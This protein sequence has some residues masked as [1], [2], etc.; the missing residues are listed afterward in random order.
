M[1]APADEGE[2]EGTGEPGPNSVENDQSVWKDGYYYCLLQQADEENKR[3]GYLCYNCREKG[4]CW[5]DCPQ[6]LR[7]ALQKAKDREGI[8]EQRLN[9]SWGQWSQGSLQSPRNGSEPKVESGSRS[10]VSRPVK[11]PSWN[12]DPQSRW[13]GP[14]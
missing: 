2:E 11:A 7:Q 10:N 12:D 1:V 3:T 6:P 14:G 5:R 4:H 8:D 13:L 9:A